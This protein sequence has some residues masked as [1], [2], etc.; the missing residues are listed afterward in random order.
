MIVFCCCAISSVVLP[1]HLIDNS[2]KNSPNP[3]EVLMPTIIHFIDV[4]QGNMVLIQTVDGKNIIFDCNITEDNE[5]RVLDYVGS[6]IGLSGSIFAFICSHRDADHMRGIK[7]LHAAFPIKSIWD[8]N[9]PGTTTNTSEY[10]NYMDLRRSIGGGTIR[11]GASDDFGRT[12]FNYLSSSDSRLPNTPNA[13]GIVIKVG[14]RDTV[15]RPLS[16]VMLPGDSDAQTWRYGILHDYTASQL[17]VDILMAAHHGSISF[18]DDPALSQYYKDHLMAINPA[19]TVV[20]VGNNPHGHPDTTA[21][22][23]YKRYSRGSDEG[24][25]TIRTDYAGSIKLTLKVGGGWSLEPQ[26]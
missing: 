12:K 6:H 17:A 21:M 11:K 24:H 3:Q 15:G 5:D 23:I 8:S 4:G 26:G 20:S 7:K 16:S 2:P 22:G 19:M 18:F 10:V 9:F 1:R 13:Q 25:K 14:Q